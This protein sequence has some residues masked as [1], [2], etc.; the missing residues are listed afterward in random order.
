MLMQFLEF[1]LKAENGLDIVY[2]NNPTPIK[3]LKVFLYVHRL[4][5]GV[6]IP[7]KLLLLSS[8]IR[9]SKPSTIPSPFKSLL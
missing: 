9:K 4:I 3:L 6:T 7:T 8:H 2:K 5:Y 1:G